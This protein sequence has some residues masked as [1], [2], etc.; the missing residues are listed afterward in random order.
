MNIQTKTTTP[1]GVRGL[2]INTFIV[3]EENNMSI[4]E[5]GLAGGAFGGM[6]GGSIGTLLAGATLAIPGVNIVVAPIMAAAA[7]T[8]IT[9]S[10]SA[11]GTAIGATAGAISGAKEKARGGD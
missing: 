4:F 3:K 9:V 7:A 1:S 5:R 6:L 10:G 11:F 2:E 8:T